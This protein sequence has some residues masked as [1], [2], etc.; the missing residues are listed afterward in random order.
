MKAKMI[1]ASTAVTADI[2]FVLQAVGT[3]FLATVLLA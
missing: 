3:D 2:L 1:K